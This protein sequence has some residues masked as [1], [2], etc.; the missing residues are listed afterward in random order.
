MAP[1][2]AKP[3]TAP[4]LE[5]RLINGALALAALRP[6]AGVHLADIARAAGSDLASLYPLYATKGAI[7]GAFGRRIDRQVLAA[8]FTGLDQEPARDRLFDVLMRR[9]EALAPHRAA[10]RSIAGAERRDWGAA[11]ARLPGF[12]ESMRW[13]VQAAQLDDAGWLGTLRVGG[14]AAAFL[15]VLP[16]FLE[17]GDDLART[18]AAL[19]RHLAS[20]EKILRRFRPSRVTSAEGHGIV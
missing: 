7:L 5:D 10:L 6:W 16:R 4:A 12:V 17:D 11:L 14:A 3:K 15:A 9:F 20:G 8:D 19:D 2:T 1:R 13:M 18:M